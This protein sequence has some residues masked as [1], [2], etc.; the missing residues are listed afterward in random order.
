MAHLCGSDAAE[1]GEGRKNNARRS[2]APDDERESILWR[3]LADFRRYRDD[4]RSVNDALA[5]FGLPKGNSADRGLQLGKR[6]GGGTV[7]CPQRL[8]RSKEGGGM[9]D[10][11]KAV[12]RRD[13]DC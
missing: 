6:R 13:W 3:R 2:G 1:A 12:M 8:G 10:G 9:A 5:Y 7:G 4:F 11:F